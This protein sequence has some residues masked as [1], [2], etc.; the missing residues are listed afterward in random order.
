MRWVLRFK[1]SSGRD[2]VEQLKSMGAVILVPV[3]G[4]AKNFYFPDLNNLTNQRIASDDDLRALGN[5]IKFSD[6]RR[7][8]VQQVA[9]TLGLD[10]RPDAFWAFFPKGL[11]DE[12]ARKETG[13]RNRRSEDIEETI[14]RVTIRG[15]SYEIVVDEQKIKR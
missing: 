1:V 15:G 2:Y 6:H 14:F 7:D 9:G 11:E 13:F 12:L 4:T 5:K 3:P 8:A 10:F